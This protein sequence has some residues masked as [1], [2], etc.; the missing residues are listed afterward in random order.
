MGRTD[1]EHKV[2][3][4]MQRAKMGYRSSRRSSGEWEVVSEKAS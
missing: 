3:I 1:K 4:T 2:I